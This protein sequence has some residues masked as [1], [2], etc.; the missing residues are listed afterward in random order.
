MPTCPSP[1]EPRTANRGVDPIDARVGLWIALSVGLAIT[2]YAAVT[3]DQ[4]HRVLVLVTLAAGLIAATVSRRWVT[5]PRFGGPIAVSWCIAVIA[6]IVALAALD[7]G[8]ESPIGALLFVP[9]AFAALAFPAAPAMT[10]AASS[11]VA[12]AGLSV[13]SGGFGDGKAAVVGAALLCTAAL[14]IRQARRESERGV[15][16]RGQHDSLMASEARFR[17]GFEHSPVGMAIVGLEKEGVIG[18]APHFEHVNEAF[19]RLLGRPRR[20]LE[21]QALSVTTHPDDLPFAKDLIERLVAE[22]ID[23][24]QHEIRYLHADGR[25]VTVLLGASNIRDAEGRI[26]SL[27]AQFVDVTA[28][29]EAAERAQGRVRQQAVVAAIGQRALEGGPIAELLNEAVTAMKDTLGIE[30]CA[31]LEFSGDVAI[32]RA[33]RGH[34]VGIELPMNDGRTLLG[35]ARETGRPALMEDAWTETRFD[36]VFARERGLA[37]GMAVPI[38]GTGDEPFGG[39]VAHAR[40]PRFFEADDFSLLQALANVLGGALARE[41]ADDRLRYLSLHDGLTGLPNRTL[42]LD[43]LGHAL[44]RV[45]RSDETVAVMFLDV[46]N[47]KTVNDA[48]GHTVGDKLLRALPPRLLWALRVGDTLARFGGDEF[49]VL[50][51]GLVDAAGAHALAERLLA[52]FEMPFVLEAEDGSTTEH[53]LSAS[54]GL[55]IAGPEHLGDPDALIRDADIAMYRAKEKRGCIEIFDA[56]AR[57]RVVERLQTL[58]E[59]RRGLEQNELFLAYQPIV[60]LSDGSIRRVEAL[61]RWRHPERGAIPPSEFIGLAEESGLILPIGAWVIDR[62]AEQLAAWDAGPDPA[63]HGMRAA[64]N[65]SARQLVEPNLVDVVT[66]ACRVHGVPAGRL[67][68]E[69][70]ETALIDDPLRAADNVEALIAAGAAVSLDDFGTGYS[71]LEHLKRFELSAIKLDR[72]FIADIATNTIDM[73]VVRGLIEI[74]RAMQIRIVAEGVERPEQ[75]ARLRELG[76]DLAQG[77]LFSPALLP[78]ELAA[79]LHRLPN[80]AYE[81][82]ALERRGTAGAPPAVRIVAG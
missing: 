66:S 43:R 57:A 58:N 64:V 19:C 6:G 34:E 33:A 60:E 38:P 67:Q 21:G 27:H 15:E 61:L 8:V 82:D 42:L 79:Y 28:E 53:F 74:A 9:V 17:R 76:C 20:W 77:F 31:A 59:L 29:H 52:S 55:A 80:G 45:R 70:T 25:P 63:L 23:Y 48:C 51:E 54:V 37:S 44:D 65:I 32:I 46:D 72:T 3:W 56:T 2:Y 1:S 24:V 36:S 13:G 71:A 26:R 5:H 10:V 78:E 69:I 12:F 14:C 16:L 4:P 62:V 50:S 49:V 7:G 22:E 68:C 41:E 39:L 40:T 35:M 75:M 30:H 73:A 47:F 11:F 18:L 81:L